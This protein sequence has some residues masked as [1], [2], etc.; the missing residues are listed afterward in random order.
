MIDKRV[1]MVSGS[2]KGS[3]KNGSKQEEVSGSSASLSA[4]EPAPGEVSTFGIIAFVL[5]CM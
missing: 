1:S 2:G 3:G 5:F 4:M